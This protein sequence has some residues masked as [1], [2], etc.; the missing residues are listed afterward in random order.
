MIGRI[1]RPPPAVSLVVFLFGAIPEAPP[2]EPAWSFTFDAGDG[3]AF[4]VAIAL[5][6]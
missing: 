6:P 5:V 2:T 3:S 4:R 1:G